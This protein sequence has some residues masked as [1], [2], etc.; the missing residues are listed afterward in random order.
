MYVSRYLLWITFIAVSVFGG[1]CSSSARAEPRY[2]SE[3]PVAQEEF[4]LA[5][6]QYQQGEAEQAE[7]LFSNFIIAH[8]ED[9]LRPAA[10]L[11]LG[12]IAAD[13]GDHDEAA[14]WLERAAASTDE[15]LSTRAR[16]ELGLCLLAAGN[17]ERALAVLEPLAGRLDGREAAELYGALAQVAEA[18]EDTPRRIRFL[19]AQC[20][21]GGREACASTQEQIAGIIA[22]LDEAV[23]TQIHES[24]PHNGD[25]W[26]AATGR[27]GVLAIDRGDGDRARALLEQL[28]RDGADQSPAGE[29]LSA[30]IEQMERVDWSAV[31]VLLP[32]TGRARLVG[33]QMRAG[34]ELAATTEED[35][36]RLLVHDSTAASANEGGING[37][38]DELVA[39]ERVS[40]IIGPVDGTNAQAAAQRAQELGVPLLSLSIRPELPDQGRWVFRAF[41][42]NE[43][44]VHALLTYSYQRLGNRTFAILHPEGNYG[45]VLR[46]LVE[47]EVEALGGSVEVVRTFSSSQTSF[48]E[49]CQELADH[50]F[51]A[52]IIPTRSRTLA[53]IAPALATVGLWSTPPERAHPEDGRAIQ[54]L[55]P[56]T[57]FSPTLIRQTGRY[58]QGAVFTT[59]LWV[60]DPDD[61]VA[62]FVEEYQESQGAAPTPYASQAYDAIQ[63][64]RAARSSAIGRSREALLDAL[65]GLTEAT[66]I[67]RFEGFD[68][69]G[70]PRAPFRLLILDGENFRR[71]A[72]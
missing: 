45:R 35:P 67:G 34:A 71:A 37:M 56:S 51:D 68:D 23:L 36:I 53:L 40:A 57:T 28:A 41:Q 15:T 54:L 22:T 25:G 32:L 26:A 21:Y 49:V 29:A 64:L 11:H 27:L 55:L 48:V 18:L 4:D 20:R 13:Q 69:S 2:T 3:D 72:P 24:L 17:A 5:R 1:G 61:D 50:T 43:A 9:P 52:L 42:S 38:I 10:E 39:T 47:L 63:I 60:G 14:I 31:G 8:P 66:T 62:R 46:E 6:A 33:E 19:D 59:P 58:L 30:A 12:R 16:H 70:E 7:Q 65:N 44:D